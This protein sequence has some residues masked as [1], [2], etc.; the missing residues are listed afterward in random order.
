MSADSVYMAKL[1]EQAERYDVRARPS[2]PV[3]FP[4][5]PLRRAPPPLSPSLSRPRT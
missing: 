4:P 5:P 2:D 1:A 3:L